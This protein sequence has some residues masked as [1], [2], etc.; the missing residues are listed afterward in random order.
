MRNKIK[1]P[2]FR[3]RFVEQMLML[4]YSFRRDQTHNCQN[5]IFVV[6]LMSDLDVQQTRPRF[7]TARVW[8]KVEL[9]I[10]LRELFIRLCE[11]EALHI[12]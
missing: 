12:F 3:G 8:L 6:I 10:D 1:I 5:I 7:F 2:L 11:R 9:K 4:S